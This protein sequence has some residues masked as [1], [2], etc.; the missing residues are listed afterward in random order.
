MLS[1]M[2]L[3]YCKETDNW[4]GKSLSHKYN[5]MRERLSER[6]NWIYPDNNAR[7]SVQK[8]Q[9]QSQAGGRKFPGIDT[10][11]QLN[12]RS[13]AVISSFMRFSFSPYCKLH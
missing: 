4:R 10:P 8:A 6:R 2:E 13:G 1:D 12:L 7:D 11:F 3:F 5:V 9:F